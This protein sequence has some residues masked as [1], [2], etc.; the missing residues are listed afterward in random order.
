MC[1]TKWALP[2]SVCTPCLTTFVDCDI[3]DNWAAWR[4]RA[5]I[6]I[7]IYIYMYKY[8]PQNAVDVLSV[9]KHDMYADLRLIS[10]WCWRRHPITKLGLMYVYTAL[11]V[12]LCVTQERMIKRI[13]A[14]RLM[15]L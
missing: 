6:C 1:G 7:Y 8:K 9:D 2:F 11:S 15:L 13:R 3:L 12:D 4:Q 10:F 5:I 14:R